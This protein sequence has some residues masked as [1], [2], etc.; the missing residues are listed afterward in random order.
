MW[1]IFGILTFIMTLLN[2]YM[3]NAGKD[4]YLFMA[5]SIFLTTLTLCAQYQM[6]AFWSLAGDWS[7]IADVAPTLSMIQWIFVIGS[8]IINVMPLLLSCRKNKV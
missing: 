8:F 2:L 7:A 3:Y 4:Y 1:I 5:L 6:I